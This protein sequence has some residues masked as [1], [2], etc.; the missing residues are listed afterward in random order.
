MKTREARVKLLSAA[1]I[2]ALE[3]AINAFLQATAPYA[4]ENP[5]R[6]LDGVSQPVYDGTNYLVVVTYTE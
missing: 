6:E 3:T 2:A 5:E 4:A 1:T